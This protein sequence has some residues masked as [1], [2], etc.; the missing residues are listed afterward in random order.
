[1]RNR[2]PRVLL[3]L[4]LLLP[5]VIVAK[6]E[7]R[8][9]AAEKEEPAKT[10]ELLKVDLRSNLT[11]WG[12]KP[13]K[14][15]ARGTCSVFVVTGAFEYAL[16]R[17]LKHGAPLS[18]EFLNWACNQITGNK[19]DVGQFFHNLLKGFE[20]Y[21]I[22]LEEHMPYQ[23]QFD[24]FLE[25]TPRAIRNAKQIRTK[26]FKVHWINPWSP[27]LGLT[28]QHFEQIRKTLDKGWPVCAGSHHSVLLVGY[29]DDGR[30]PGGGRF[31]AEDS[32]MGGFR[33]LTYEFVKANMAD[34][35]WVE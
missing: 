7:E 26:G 29:E 4:G 33:E 10:A 1:M 28:D 32:G 35:F 24:P 6:G 20:Q 12:L 15:G 16:S 13:R 9:K 21:G 2:V 11:R 31:M 30:Q 27:K 22:C 17:R 19:K 3:A 14:Q 23:P 34:V 5:W 25:P 8:H 18:A